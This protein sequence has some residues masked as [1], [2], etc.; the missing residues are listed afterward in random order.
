ML[1]ILNMS[2]QNNKSK[3]G[4]GVNYCHGLRDFKGI[5]LPEDSLNRLDILLC[6]R[7]GWCAAKGGCFKLGATSGTSRIH[8]AA[9]AEGRSSSRDTQ[10]GPRGSRVAGVHNLS[11]CF[12]I[13]LFLWN[14]G[15]WD[16]H[17][18][19]HVGLAWPWGGYAA[20]LGLWMQWEPFFPAPGLALIYTMPLAQLLQSKKSSKCYIKSNK[21]TF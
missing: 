17:W 6:W 21:V 4:S 7:G 2:R 16:W 10:G 15:W 12:P 18:R 20:W 19:C 14:M 1:L 3:D 9:R 11:R 8:E 5:I 13:L